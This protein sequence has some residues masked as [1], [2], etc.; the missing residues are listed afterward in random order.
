M[1][2]CTV[3]GAMLLTSHFDGG[4]DRSKDARD[5]KRAKQEGEKGAHGSS[6]PWN[7]LG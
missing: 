7:P 5:S 2:F 4:H 1:Q 6:P 3:T